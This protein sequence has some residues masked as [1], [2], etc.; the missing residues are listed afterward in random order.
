MSK[1]VAVVAIDGPSGAGKSTLAHSLAENLSLLYVDTGAMFRA[2]GLA[3]QRRGLPFEE[4]D[5]AQK[6]LA[7]I[8]FRYAPAEREGVLVEVDGEDLT[9]DIRQNQASQWASQVS[10]LPCVRHY[11]LDCQRNLPQNR[12][13][14]MEGRDVGSVVFPDAFCKF[15]V[16]AKV[17]VRA[18]RRWR[19]LRKQCENPPGQK[20]IL[21]DL[22]ERDRRDRE[23]HHAPLVQ[24]EDA[25]V[26]DTSDLTLKEA[27]ESMLTTVRQQAN[28]RQLKL[29]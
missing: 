5:A 17:E 23:R 25:V 12:M 21:Q 29:P 9:R 16:T 3:F 2:I 11:L 10:T 1:T 7:E 4:G 13:C 20:E 14:V 15:F 28:Q 8:E 22:E 26:L 24:V 19:Q 18:Q 27:L 6:L